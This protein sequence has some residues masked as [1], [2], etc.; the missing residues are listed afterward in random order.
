MSVGNALKRCQNSGVVFDSTGRGLQFAILLGLGGF[1]G[2]KIELAGRGIGANLP[3]PIVFLV[4]FQP[5]Q[6][7]LALRRG[8]V[9]YGFLDFG[10][11]HTPKLHDCW[12][13]GKLNIQGRA[14]HAAMELRK[15]GSV[16]LLQ[17]CLNPGE[18]LFVGE[19][20]SG[21]AVQYGVHHKFYPVAIRRVFCNETVASPK[22]TL[23]NDIV[24]GRFQLCV[25]LGHEG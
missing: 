6:Q 21:L 12:P 7:L 14:A 24:A 22:T 11:A 19:F 5:A 1:L 23:Q 20:K 3:I 18:P 15:S 13:R 17:V 4:L 8:Q 25:H 2:E 16:L 9:D 10:Q